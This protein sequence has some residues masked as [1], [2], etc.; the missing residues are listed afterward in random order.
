MAL[1]NTPSGNDVLDGLEDAHR[2]VRVHGVEICLA[3]RLRVTRNLARAD[4]AQGLADTWLHSK[5]G[6]GHLCMATYT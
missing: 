6:N 3:G 5:T 4:D 1:A 2:L